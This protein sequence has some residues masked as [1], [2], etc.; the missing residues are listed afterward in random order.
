M[1]ISSGH[2]PK[3]KRFLELICAGLLLIAVS[4]SLLEIVS[5]LFFNAT[6]DF[7]IDLSIWFTI[8]SMLLI[9]GPLLAEKG[10]V[11]IDFIR[12]R[13]SPGPQRF[14]D[15]VNMCMSL[16][17][18]AAVTLGGIA[19]IKQLYI[20]QAVFPRYFPI[21]KWIVELCVPIGMAIFS[22]YAL[23]ELIRILRKR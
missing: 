12:S 8:W 10:H 4:I 22:I 1:T 19:L 5:R 3:A 9:S 14:L 6:F 20:R 13:M 7:I 17:Y 15:A 11:S 18:G 16:V 2:E 21:P 23:F